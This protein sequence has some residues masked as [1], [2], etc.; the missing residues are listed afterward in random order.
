[1]ELKKK[2][3]QSSNSTLH[4]IYPL[5]VVEE[6]KT[7]HLDLLF[8]TNKEDYHY[9]YMSNFSRLKR[10]QKTAYKESCIL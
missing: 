2:F 10:A 3:N 9:V 4:I 7:E 8:I 5:K 1:M 6:E